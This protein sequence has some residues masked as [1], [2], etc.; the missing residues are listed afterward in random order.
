VA[1]LAALLGWG[2]TRTS[3]P[4]L[5]DPLHVTESGSSW[6]GALHQ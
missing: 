6:Q 1:T 4:G 5:D 2:H 3:D